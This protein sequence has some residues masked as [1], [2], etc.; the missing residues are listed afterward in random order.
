MRRMRLLK[1][2]C[3]WFLI[4]LCLGALISCGIFS[5]SGALGAILAV[6]ALP[7][8]PV[9][10]LWKK[11]LPPGSP[12]FAKEAILLAA[13]LVMMAAAPPVPEEKLSMSYLL[14]QEATAETARLA[15]PQEKEKIQ[16]SEPTVT[17]Q[18][19]E[20][21]AAVSSDTEN[22]NSQNDTVYVAGS[23]EGSKYHSDPYCSS[24]KNPI[25]MTKAE[26]ESS[27]YVPCQRCCDK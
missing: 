12:R 20:V 7:V 26:A 18:R 23:G 8:A 5:V 6:L 10:A 21:P 14:M 19:T 16:T 25:A 17:A 22:G 11:I 15:Q 9:R 3:R 1:T 4:L 13:F 2:G 27:G 24:M